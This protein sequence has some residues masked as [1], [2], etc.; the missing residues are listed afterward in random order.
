[1]PLTPS[2]ISEYFR[3]LQKKSAKA[4]FGAMN[5]EQKSAHFSKLGKLSTPPKKG[6]AKKRAVR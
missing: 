4:Q 6:I 5:K 3:N 2:E 1:M